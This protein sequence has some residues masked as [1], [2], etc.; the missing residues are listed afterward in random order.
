VSD[1]VDMPVALPP[2]K[3]QSVHAHYLLGTRPDDIVTRTGVSKC[4]V[5]RI[6]HN[7]CNYGTTVR[8]KVVK[9]GRRRLMTAEMEEVYDFP[10]FY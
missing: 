4:S 9:Q 10:C 6:K 3:R 7:L 8:P 2:S 5:E 1:L